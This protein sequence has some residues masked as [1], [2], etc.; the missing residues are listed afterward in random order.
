MVSAL[1]LEALRHPHQVE[2]RLTPYQGSTPVEIPGYPDGLPITGG[3]IQIDATQRIRRQ[4]TCTI[5][6]PNLAP[7]AV[8]DLL[9]LTGIELWVSYGIRF[10]DGSVEWCP[11]GLFHAEEVAASV[12]GATEVSLQ[13][14]SDRGGYVT[15]YRFITAEQSTPDAAAAAEIARLMSAA[16]PPGAINSAVNMLTSNVTVAASMTWTDADRWGAISQ[17]EDIIGAESFF[18]AS[19]HP[20][21]R[22]VATTA[23]TPV[24]TVDAGATG[25]MISANRRTGRTQTYNGVVAR[26]ERTD[27]TDPVQVLVTDNNSASP[28]YWDGPFGRKPRFYSSPLIT[29]TAQA[30]AAGNA[31]LAKVTGWTRVIELESVVNPTLEASD[32]ITVV[33]PS[34]V[35]EP[36]IIDQITLPL[37]E[38]GAMTIATRTYMPPS[39]S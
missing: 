32:V 28:T 6:D 25:V 38:D 31:I 9:G 15:D 36:H 12:S 14:T 23:D 22:P 4:L 24:W 18:N 20:T 10:P 13:Q 3:Q 17:L 5:G 21:I 39:E 35:S 19:G 11:V 16:I 1:F 34:G 30:E 29:N 26:G 27:D 8:T 33:Y 37:S 7:W 2:R